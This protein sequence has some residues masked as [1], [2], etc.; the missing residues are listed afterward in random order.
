MISF[1]SSLRGAPSASS[2]VVASY[3][4]GKITAAD[5]AERREEP[6]FLMD[7]NQ[8]APANAAISADEK[9]A[10]HLAAMRILVNT[11]VERGFAKRPDWPL[12]TKL[13]EQRVLAEALASETREQAF[14][15]DK[16]F[17]DQYATNRFKL[18]GFDSVEA[19]RIGI[20]AAKHG[21]KALERAKAALKLIRAGKDFGAV[22]RDYSDLDPKTAEKE[23][24][25]ANFW[26]RP[27]GLSLAEVGEGN[28][29]EPIETSY[30][31]ELVKV[32][33][34][35][36][37]GNPTPEQAKADL[38][39]MLRELSAGERLEQMAKGAMET[40]PLLEG[41]AAV[42]ATGNETNPVVLRCGL[43]SLTREDVH[44]LAVQRG[45]PEMTDDKMLEIIKQENG[46][47]QLGELARSMGYGQRPAV[48]KALRYQLDKHLADQA[49]TALL[50]ELAAAMSFDES[51]IRDA[52]EKK[53]TATFDPLLEYDLL[54]IPLGVPANAT[55]EQRESARTNAQ[56]RAEALIKRIQDG[57]SFDSIAHEPGLQLMAGQSRVVREGS[58]LFPLVTGLK[59][60]EVAKEPYEDFGGLCLIR[61][62]K[63]EPRR[64]MPYDLARNYII[65]DFRTEALGELRANFEP[66]LLTKYHFALG[67]PPAVPAQSPES[68]AAGKTNV[69]K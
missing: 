63:Y 5:I 62:N 43:F 18:L 36:I 57:A 58:A 9:I 20:S 19:R 11:A 54:L 33:H 31:F 64:K 22:A 12:E 38:R 10:R 56:A 65:N 15:S 46:Q 28:V 50:P 59:P 26:G 14:V 47:I 4:G 52:Y 51:R 21:A 61:V 35:T 48:Q 3:D 6:M 66:A 32:E 30:G 45:V 13:I 7:A 27:A 41:K 49:R 37:R 40:F 8:N 42:A 68:A 69:E 25:P 24:Y 39:L 34:I 60:G 44:G 55:P 2:A 23:S 29:S 1:G 17:E 53:F 67:A 16:E